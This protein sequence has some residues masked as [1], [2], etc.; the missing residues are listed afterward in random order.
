[1]PVRNNTPRVKP[2]GHC[3]SRIA[4]RLNDISERDGYTRRAK[5]KGETVGAPLP[6]PRARDGARQ[7]KRK[8]GH[9]PAGKNTVLYVSSQW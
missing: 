8:G 5:R 4:A 6:K 7:A 2:A 9:A 3:P 1:M